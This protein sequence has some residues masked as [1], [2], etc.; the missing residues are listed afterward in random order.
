M[1]DKEATGVKVV[2]T[3]PR[4]LHALAERLY[5]RSISTVLRDQ[6]EQQADLRFA[7]RAIRMLLSKLD[8]G[9]VHCTETA[10]ELRDLSIEVEG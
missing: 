5:N 4:E 3:S 1:G 6:P 8:V 9:A 10:K 7:A 2:N